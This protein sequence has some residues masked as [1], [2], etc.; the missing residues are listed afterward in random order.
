MSAKPAAGQ[1]GAF[2]ASLRKLL[3][4][5]KVE[6][7]IQDGLTPHDLRHSVATDLRELGKTEHEIADILGQR[8]TYAVPTYSRTADMKRSNAQSMDDLYGPRKPAAVLSEVS[9][10]G[11]WEDDFLG[12]DRS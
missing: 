4:K 8:T 12:S 10:K 2:H 6:G 3:T 9:G 11:V 1:E 5:L 7:K